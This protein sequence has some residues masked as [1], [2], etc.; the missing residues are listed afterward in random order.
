MKC[1]CGN[2][3]F[4]AHQVCHHDVI[5]DGDGEFSAD[6]GVYYGGRPFGPF[7]CTVCGA[8]YEELPQPEKK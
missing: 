8:E 7:T 6:K 5:T 2:D 4:I 1:K 3:R